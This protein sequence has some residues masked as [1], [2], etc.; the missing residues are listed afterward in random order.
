[1]LLR[2]L[3]KDRTFAWV[4][5]TLILVVRAAL[6]AATALATAAVVRNLT[7]GLAAVDGIYLPLVALGAVL[8]L[9]QALDGI[10]DPLQFHVAHRIDG[11]HRQQV[12][13]ALRQ[14]ETIAHLEDPALQD[15][16]ELA[17]AEPANWTEYSPGMAVV[18]QCVLLSRLLKAALSAA[19]LW[20]VV[21]PL[22]VVVL[23]GLLL[24]LRG[25]MRRK[26][27]SL[28]AVWAGNTKHIRRAG[29]WRDVSSGPE[30]A[31][32]LRIFGFFPWSVRQYRR[33]TLDHLEPYRERKFV[34][35]RAQWQL[36]TVSALS[37]GTALLVP[38]TMAAS[39]RLNS[40]ELATAL[41]AGLGMLSL[42][43]MGYEAMHIEGGLPS[44]R[45]LQKL[46]ALPGKRPATARAVRTAPAGQ[47]PPLLAFESVSFT[48]PGGSRRVLENLDLTVK[49]GEVLGIVGAN[50]AGKTTLIKLLSRLYD[51]GQ[52]RIT[53]DGVDLAK[54]DRDAWQSRLAV[55]FQGFVR[56]ELSLRDNVRMGRPGAVADPD[57]LHSVAAEAGI[58]KLVRSLPHGWDTPLS[59]SRSNGV[60]L[61]GGQWQRVAIARALFALRTGADVLVLDEPT[62]NL[63]VRTEFEVFSL[64]MEA[65][66][67]ST[68]LLVSH[69]LFTVKEADRIVMLGDG[70]VSESGTHAELMA[71][72]GEYARMFRLQAHRF[73]GADDQVSVKGE[74][75]RHRSEAW[76]EIFRR[77]WRLDRRIA[78]SVL[79]LLVVSNAAFLIGGLAL[80]ALVD[81][82]IHREWQ[83]VLVAAALGAVAWAVVDIGFLM[84]Q[85]LRMD[86]SDRLGMLDV[87]EEIQR[88]VAGIPT[89]DHLENPE[90][91]D[92]LELVRGQGTVLVQACWALLY[93]ASNF[94]RVLITLVLLGSIHPALLGL[95]I[96][97]LPPLLLKRVGP[98]KARK[99]QLAVAETARLERHLFGLLT[100]SRAAPELRITGAGTEL[101]RQVEEA[102][103]AEGVI[104]ARARYLGAAASALGW[105]L[106]MVGYVAGLFYVV[107]L[108][109]QGE[110]SIGDLVLAV[111]LAGQL[112]AQIEQAISQTAPVF[113]GIAALEPFLWLRR[114]AA[115][116]TSAQTGGQVPSRLSHGVMLRDVSFRYPGQDRDALSGVTLDL[117]AG[118]IIA[119]VGEHGSGK[120]TLI[121]L[122]TGL[123]QPSSGVI[124]IDG[125]P[126]KDLDLRSWRASCGAVFQDFGRYRT[127]VRAAVGVGDVDRIDDSARIE[128]ALAAADAS[129]IVEAL[130]DGLE[131]R[132][133]REF[134]G[135]ELSEGQWQRVGLARGAMRD[136]P[137]LMVLDEPTAALDATSEYEIF[138][139]QDAISRTHATA[140]GTITLIV[141]HRF[142]T[143]AMADLIVVLHE[144]RVVEQGDHT[145]LMQLN[146]RYAATYRLQQEAS[147]A[148]IGVKLN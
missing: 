72:D 50:G 31:K 101:A 24:L 114:Y 33:A 145:T 125:V 47:G 85:E 73:L 28:I 69:R 126:L 139:A 122:L 95:A 109:A 36:L 129:S 132:L 18:G 77:S 64:L 108:V 91:L 117:P 2:L 102:W 144:G 39:G 12:I 3:P 10:S 60:D 67:D 51:P 111:A 6:P 90:Y 121:K 27:M 14:P 82:A 34:I 35:L 13:R 105:T 130:P 74:P 143:I 81:A 58:E 148:G 25:M 54:I 56:Y 21:S 22:L 100:D 86:L 93:S 45:A 32:E 70:A 68:V 147:A 75:M 119:V 137:L 9:D 19:V 48:Y 17:S 141:T 62:A 116:Q 40:V 131:T 134:G 57:V 8:L 133:G 52:G 79:A 42:G 140:R 98:A 96:F 71:H 112:R 124:D 94:V 59:R 37:I 46:E 43:W 65:A 146:G 89:L 61:S 1:M 88:N 41:T 16:I 83:S 136:D 26:W 30:T 66:R 53:A 20:V 63:D 23:L 97:A 113:A 99:A 118:R 55:V 103:R 15:A 29:Y 120:T 106:F 84:E 127:S 107:Y 115:Q 5:M 49:P 110:R 92:R 135:V 87:D 123:Y 78:A 104:E 76:L 44:V 11:V 138:Q 38:S 142:S 128:R 4:G 7:D 80:R